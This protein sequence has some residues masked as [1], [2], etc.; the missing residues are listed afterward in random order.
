MEPLRTAL[1]G[2]GHAGSV[3]HA[4]LIAA[5]PALELSAVVTGNDARRAEVR[6][7]YPGAALLSGAEDIWRHSGDYDLV[8]VA[9]PNVSHAPLAAAALDA[10]LDV[11]VDKPFALTSAS[12]RG[13]V[14]R[15]TQLGRMLTVFQNR[16]WDADFRAVRDLVDSGRLGEVRRFTSRF[17]RWQPGKEDAWRYTTPRGQG[18]GV[19]FDLGAHLI[20]QAI[21]LFGPVT[22][23]YA[24]AS[25]VRETA[26]TTD[27]EDDA[28]LALRHRGG[29]YSHLHM[30][31]VAPNEAPRF[32]LVGTSGGHE[33]W[34][35]DPQEDQLREGVIADP[36][37]YPVF[38]R[39]VAA[40]VRGE[41]PAP[42]DPS[43]AVAVLEVIERAFAATH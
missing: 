33:T 11:V 27:A 19:I 13:L 2:F 8:V 22:E 43:D 9:T 38:Y 28:F 5:E 39:Q 21:R 17:D 25:V 34:G 40:A 31:M 20:D 7:S 23:V 15:A 18:G 26:V 35:L 12:G 16:R 14:E 32:S 1:I 30:S 10:G 24:E 4:P 37:G 41:A 3:F 42:V 29:V 36:D 6:R